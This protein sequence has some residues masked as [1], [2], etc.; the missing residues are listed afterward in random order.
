MMKTKV[1]IQEIA[2]FTGLS[3]FA[4]SRA[5]SGKSGVSDQTRDVILKA[6][7]K[8]GYFKDNAALS[9]D[10]HNSNDLNDPQNIR[11]S[12]TI[13]ILFP[14][15]RYQNQESVYWGP[16]FNGISSR[17]NQKGINILTLTEPSADQLFTLLNPD[18]I[19]G[20]ITVGSISTP[21]LLEIKRL[22]IPVVMVD[23]LDP[24]FHSDSIFTDNFASM[25][26]IMLYLLR[27][28]FKR[29]QFVGN[30][31]DA[32]SFYERWLAYSS[33]L[34]G[35]G[36]ELNQIPELSSPDLEDFRKT[37]SSQFNETNL[38][39]V[40]VCAND[41]YALSTI[42]TLESMGIRVPDQCVVTGFDNVY[43]DIPMLASVNVNKE[44][45]GARA[46]DQMLWRIVNPESNVEK[47]LI[48]ADV[49][50][51]EQ[52]GRHSG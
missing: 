50:I 23:H 14:N 34:V 26:D 18:A 45:L 24:V 46:V 16:V 7:G 4:V 11:W 28:G 37:F 35:H 40:F 3:K 19:R 33:V 12:G 41:F 39:E 1:T 9:G 31:H 51:R 44:L 27:K 22:G 2:H 52:F 21:I 47:K 30:I 42:Q 29:F 49:I 5:L 17:L 6:A 36:I 15:V 10:V 20:I 38:P 8:L 43:N 32:H 13:L 25:R 48:L